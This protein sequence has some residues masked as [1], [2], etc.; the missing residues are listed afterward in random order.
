MFPRRGV[1]GRPS[2][3]TV[4][5]GVLTFPLDKQ[6]LRFCEP[7]NV[8][9]TAVSD[10][11]HNKIVDPYTLLCEVSHVLGRQ[12]RTLEYVRQVTYWSG[13]SST[14]VFLGE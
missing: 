7:D 8:V 13:V 1:K 14:V 12:L 10:R 2:R 4:E 9:Q 11:C 6:T 5:T 3:V